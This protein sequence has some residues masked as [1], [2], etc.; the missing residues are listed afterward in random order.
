[1]AQL[2][3]VKRLF[4]RLW[5]EDA[6]SCGEALEKLRGGRRL[7]REAWLDNCIVC[8]LNMLGEGLKELDSDCERAAALREV[9]LFSRQLGGIYRDAFKYIVKEF[10]ELYNIECGVLYTTKPLHAVLAF[11]KCRDR[12]QLAYV[13][14]VDLL[15]RGIADYIEGIGEFPDILRPKFRQIYKPCIERYT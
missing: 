9:E 4:R 3:I 14:A 15:W 5:P 6:H 1:M 2:K 13:R 8:L 12:R 10:A 7:V 11:Y